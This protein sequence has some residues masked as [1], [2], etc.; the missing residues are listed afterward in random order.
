MASI[1]RGLAA[2]VTLLALAGCT[3][4]EVRTG[5]Y[6]IRGRSAD[7]LDRQIRKFGPDRGHAIAQAEIRFEPVTLTLAE[8]KGSCRFSSVRY[9][10]LADISLPRWADSD[11]ADPELRRAFGNLQDYARLHERM[12]VRIAEAAARSLE[13]RLRAIPAQADCDTL[14]RMAKAEIAAM[15]K[16]HDN[17]QKEFDAE[18]QRRLT[19]LMREA[20]RRR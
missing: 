8:R 17:A 12:H 14:E 3:T 13:R 16:L 10:V 20:E 7:D 18:E 4:T 6:D 15:R 5:Y 11:G 2:A 19:A 9:R 1:L